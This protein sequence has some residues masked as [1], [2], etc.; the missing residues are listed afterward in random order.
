M[1]IGFASADWSRSVFDANGHPVWGGSGWA[2]LGQY[3]PLLPHD[4]TVGVLCSRRDEFGVRDWNGDYHFG[5]DIILMQRVMFGSIVGKVG[6][7]V[8]NGQV[9][10]NDVDDWYWGMSPANHAYAATNPKF[11]PEENINHYRKILNE[12]SAIIASTPYLAGRL[13]DIIAPNIEVI[14]N[15]IDL[16]RFSPKPHMPMDR[17][18]VGWVG[19]TSHRSNDLETLRGMGSQILDFGRLHHSGH[20]Q[21]ART[22]AEAIGVNEAMVSTLPM[23]SPADYPSLLVMDIGVV[24]L[25]DIPFNH[26]KSY[27]KGLEY[28]AAGIPFVASAV[29]EYI[30][31]ESEY[32][33]GRTAKKPVKWLKHLRELTDYETR[34]LE[35]KK[36]R[37]ALTQFDISVGARL[38][39]EFLESL[40]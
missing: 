28:A 5:F 11:N 32:G 10:V 22:F 18:I 3:V 24:P 16:A 34:T 33:I 12:S 6:R 9:I 29:G 2:R 27:I 4:V 19:S 17:P 38:L 40:V 1:K 20:L 13:G 35:A 31:L 14:N 25:T 15:Y 37:E 39:G 7:A 21:G 23:A 8:A 26:A 30:R 36:N